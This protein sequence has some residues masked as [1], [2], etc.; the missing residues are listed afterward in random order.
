MQFIF[1][2]NIYKAIKISGPKHNILGLAIDATGHIKEC[3][4][5]TLDETNPEININPSD[6]EEQ[7]QAGIREINQQFG[8]NFVVKEIQYVP[9][10]TPSKTIYKEL[11][12]EILKRV[13][14]E[15]SVRQS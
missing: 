5:V 11:T 7:V 4:I 3:K 13:I 10:D 12:I 1:D 14:T 2:G 6:V 9:A 15:S 8:V